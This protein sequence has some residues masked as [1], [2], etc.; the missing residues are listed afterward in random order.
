MKELLQEYANTVDVLSK[1]EIIKQAI[2]LSGIDLDSKETMIKLTTKLLKEHAEYKEVCD[3]VHELKA[4]LKV[5][6][7]K[8]SIAEKAMPLFKN[9]DEYEK[10]FQEEIK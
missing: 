5:L 3:G 8:L 2:E 9:I 7:Q 10:W 6:E 4:K 1:H